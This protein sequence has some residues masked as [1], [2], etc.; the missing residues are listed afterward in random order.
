M[1]RGESEGISLSWEGGEA[2]S[3]IYGAENSWMHDVAST[4]QPMQLL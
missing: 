3:R 1:G 4:L 2:L